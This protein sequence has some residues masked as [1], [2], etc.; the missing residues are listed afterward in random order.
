MHIGKSFSSSKKR[1]L[2]DNFK[3]DKDPK[4][5]K[6]ATSSSSYSNH[7]TLE[8]GLESSTCR[9]ILFDYLKIL[10]PKVYLAIFY[11]QLL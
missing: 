7:D 8:E 11:S 6:E 3:D 4:K 5:T 9:N 2:S 10:E 1:D